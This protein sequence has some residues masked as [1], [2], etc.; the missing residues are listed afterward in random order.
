MAINHLLLLLI[1]WAI[2]MFLIATALLLIAGSTHLPMLNAYIVVFAPS[3]L[4]MMLTI[5]PQIAHEHK[6]AEEQWGA[7]KTLRAALVILF[8]AT[9][10]SAAL[11]V[12]HLHL[13]NNVPAVVSIIG[14]AMF[15][16]ASL[17]QSWAMS[18]NSFYSPLIHIQ[19]E[20]G[21][22]VVT[23]GP[24]RILRHPAYFANIIAV[25]ASALAIG[26][27]VALIPAAVCCALTVWRARKEDVFLKE[28]LPGYREYMEEVPGGVLPSLSLKL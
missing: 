8:I 7:D 2:L 15:A 20:R 6:Q 11:D 16:G 22:R 17:F 24:Y 21:H 3:L 10:V 26:S 19:A 14:L 4:A 25:P 5:A 28:H 18:V 9:V 1:R 27:W 12:G 13:S 23:R